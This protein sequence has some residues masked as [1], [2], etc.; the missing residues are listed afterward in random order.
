[1]IRVAAVAAAVLSVAACTPDQVAQWHAL[2][3]RDPVAAQQIVDALRDARGYAYDQVCARWGCDQWPALEDLWQR[4]SHWQPD[5]VN[6][7][8]GACGIPQRYPCHGL[9]LEHPHR[10]VDWGLDYIA[11][12]YGTPH[13]ALSAWNAKGWY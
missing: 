12:R 7:S 11:A 13:G 2:R 9:H 4:E 3:D 5:A 8:S 10:Q 1:V 6:P